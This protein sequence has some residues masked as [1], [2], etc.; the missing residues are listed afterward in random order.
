MRTFRCRVVAVVVVVVV[1]VEVAVVTV[2]VLLVVVVVLT[3][4]TSEFNVIQEIWKDMIVPVVA[5]VG[6]PA[7]ALS[8]SITLHLIVADGRKSCR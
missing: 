5:A 6:F 3:R 2:V 4:E 7:S 1:E 8:L